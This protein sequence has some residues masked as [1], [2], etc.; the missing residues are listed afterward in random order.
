MK[1]RPLLFS[2]IV[3]TSFIVSSQSGSPVNSAER[4]RSLPGLGTINELQLAGYLPLSGP[5]CVS[6]Q[7]HNK[8][9]NLFYWFVASPT[10][11]TKTPIVLWLNG[12]PGAAS[13]YGFFM[14]NGPYTVQKN[15]H[16][17]KRQQGYAVD[18]PN[19]YI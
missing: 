7:C 15:G 3:Y 2:F 17:A 14:E 8:T 13:L 16:L 6:Y 4:I 10:H 9:G 18:Q 19:H 1:I 11:S 12:G 5:D